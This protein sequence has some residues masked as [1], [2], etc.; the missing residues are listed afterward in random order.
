MKD[1]KVIDATD[2]DLRDFGLLGDGA[3]D[4]VTKTIQTIRKHPELLGNMTLFMLQCQNEC[5][6]RRELAAQILPTPSVALDATIVD[7]YGVSEYERATYYHGISSE[8][9]ELLYRSDIKTNPFPIPKGRFPH[10]GVKTAHGV[11]NTP[12]NTV[13]HIVAPK[14]V[15]LLKS[16]GIRYSVVKMARFTTTFDETGEDGSLGPIVIWIATHPG[17][18]AKDA[19]DT[20]PAILEI[21]ETYQVEGVVVEWYEGA[22]E[23]LAG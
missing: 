10:L 18:T 14:I 21:L 20:S 17:T 6:K 3:S 1:I 19:Y 12:L 13:W 5:A 8:P 16:R 23:K 22:V 9:P 7:P 2:K 11:F 4:T 15:S